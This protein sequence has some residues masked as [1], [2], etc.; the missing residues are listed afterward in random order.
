MP[1]KPVAVMPILEVKNEALAIISKS[2]IEFW[3]YS[4]QERA[5]IEEIIAACGITAPAWLQLAG[6]I[7]GRDVAKFAELRLLKGKATGTSAGIVGA[8]PPPEGR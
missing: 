4:P 6:A 1:L 3:Q 7:A 2:S 5:D 8:E